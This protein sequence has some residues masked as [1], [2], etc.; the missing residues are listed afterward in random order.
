MGF[1]IQPSTHKGGEGGG[2]G[3]KG[4]SGVHRRAASEAMKEQV[5]KQAK[6]QHE[7]LRQGIILPFPLPSPSLSSLF[8]ESCVLTCVRCCVVLCGAA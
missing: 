7:M 3:E 5:L 2:G 8:L 6:A 1:N 4:R